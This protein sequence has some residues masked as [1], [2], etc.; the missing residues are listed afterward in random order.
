MPASCAPACSRAW[1]EWRS[2]FACWRRATSPASPAPPPPRSTP[3]GRSPA[4]RHTAPAL[5]T[6]VAIALLACDAERDG[7]AW[8]VPA[9]YQAVH[10]LFRSLEIGPYAYLRAPTLMVLAQRYWPWVGGFALLILGWILYTVR[11]EY[12]VQKRTAALREALAE[13]E[14]GSKHARRTGAGRAPAAPVGAGRAVGHA[15]ARAQPAAGRHRQL[16]QQPDPPRRQPAPHRRRLA[17]G[18]R[19]DRRPGRARRRHPGPHPRLRAQAHRQPRRRRTRYASSWTR[20]SPCSAACWRTRRRSS[21]VDTLPAGARI[22]VDRLQIQQ[23]LLNLLK[24]GWD[25]SRELPPARQRSTVRLERRRQ[26]CDILRTRL[27]QRTRRHR[28]RNICSKPS[29]PPRPTASGWGCRSAAAS[30][31]PTAGA[32]S[33]PRL[34]PPGRPSDS[35]PGTCFTLSLPGLTCDHA[36]D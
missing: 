34:R 28:P 32:S 13:R 33:P 35:G 27:R 10:E 3:T 8:A 19:R 11:V 26:A 2:A 9:D 36:H 12:L 4:L 14:A 25:A 20:P 7:L 15:R 29:S 17:R 31:K 23:V 22:D 24:N 16:R 18:H 21:L 1:A 5:A 6:A 30:P